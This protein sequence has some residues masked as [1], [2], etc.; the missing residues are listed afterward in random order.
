[1]DSV[2]LPNDSML[3]SQNLTTLP[4]LAASFLREFHGQ[5]LIICFVWGH[6]LDEAAWTH[7][8]IYA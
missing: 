3:S 5:D 8:L 2:I 6:D 1:M 4:S 7:I